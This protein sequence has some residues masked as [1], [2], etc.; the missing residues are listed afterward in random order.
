MC[1]YYLNFGFYM[2]ILEFII[3]GLV[4]INLED[5]MKIE[6]VNVFKYIFISDI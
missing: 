6:W 2:Y 3:F 1:E 4:F 5:Y